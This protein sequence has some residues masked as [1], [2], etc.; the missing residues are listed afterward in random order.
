[1]RASFPWWRYPVVCMW[2]DEELRYS[3]TGGRTGWL[4]SNTGKLRSQPWQR[5]QTE[6][7]GLGSSISLMDL[8]C[9]IDYQNVFFPKSWYFAA[10]A[11]VM[12]RASPPLWNRFLYFGQQQGLAWVSVN[13]H[14]FQHAVLAN[15][16]LMPAR[17]LV[18]LEA[19]REPPLLYTNSRFCTPSCRKLR[20]LESIN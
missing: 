11:M 8:L 20:V 18:L 4:A 1:M 3:P 10:Q 14:E 15:I 12:V 17:T 13:S 16:K 7:T 19:I 2:L 6:P 9:V 5:F